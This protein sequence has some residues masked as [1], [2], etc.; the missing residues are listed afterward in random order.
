MAKINFGGVE[1][2]VV[3]REEFPLEKAREVLKNEVVAVLGYGVQGPAQAMNMRDNGINVIV[4]QKRR[5]FQLGQGRR[6][7]LGSGQDI[8]LH[9][10]SRRTRDSHSV[11]AFGCRPALTM[12]QDRRMPER[13]RH[14]LFLTWLFHHIQR[15]DRCYPSAACGCGAGCPEGIGPQRAHQLPG[16]L[17]HQCQLCR[18][19]GCDRARQ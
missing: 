3:T 10:R 1:E 14:A 9:R 5:Q 7:W 18:S 17:R 16:W 8:I 6:R 2:E 19:A 13:R 15:S 4:G 12:A 11:F